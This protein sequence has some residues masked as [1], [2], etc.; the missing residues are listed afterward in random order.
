MGEKKNQ[1]K[2][3]NSVEFK[4]IQMDQ[5]SWAL[6]QFTSCTE[7][8]EQKKKKKDWVKRRKPGQGTE[9]LC[10]TYNWLDPSL[11]CPSSEDGWG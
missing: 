2:T 1:N 5:F 7:K 8:K 3:I 9:E 4:K 11:W 10:M 6:E